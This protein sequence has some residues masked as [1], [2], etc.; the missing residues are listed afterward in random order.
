MQKISLQ[1]RSF[2][3]SIGLDTKN[4]PPELQIKTNSIQTK[5]PKEN[6]KFLNEKDW[7]IPH[8]KYFRLK[9]MFG[10]SNI[11][12]DGKTWIE[13]F[14]ENEKVEE[15]IKL[16]FKNPN[17]YYR[18]LKQLNQSSSAQG[19][20]IELYEDNG[21]FFVKEG[22]ARIALMMIKYLLEMSRAE[23]KEEKA[24]INKQ[25]VFSAIVRAT[26]KDRD[27]MYLINM[28]SEFYGSRVK[29]KKLD[30]DNECGYVM[31]LDDKKVEIKS[32][33]DFE[34]LIKNIYLPRE[35]KSYDKLKL[36]LRNVAKVGFEYK[37]N[38]ECDELV[39]Q[40]LLMGK[41][42][43]NYEIFIKYYKKIIQYKIEDDF[44]LKL[45]INN[46]TYDDVLKKL[47]KVVK[48]EEAM[49]KKTAETE[50]KKK[51]ISK[52][53]VSDS[54]KVASDKASE[55][56]SKEAETAAKKA[57]SSVKK[58]QKDVEAEVEQ[59]VTEKRIAEKTETKSKAKI[60]SRVDTKPE[61]D[62]DDASDDKIK[63]TKEVASTYI[64]NI[65]DNIEMTF[66]KLKSEE[67]RSMDLANSTGVELNIDKINDATINTNINSIKESS[68][69]LKK[70]IEAAKV[71]QDLNSSKETLEGLKALSGDKSIITEYGNEMK[72]IYMTSFNKNA[73]KMITDAKLKKLDKQRK[74]IEAEKCSFFSKLIGRAKLKQ[75]RLDNINLKE[76]LILTDSQYSS[77][78]YT[79][80]EDGLSD[81][82]AYVKTE[83]DAT[84][85]S[86]VKIYL[87]NI[88]SN[89]LL[90]EMIDRDKL[91]KKTRE[92]IDQQRNLPQIALSKEK[93]HLF[94]KAQIN[95]VQ[96]KNNELK[97]VIQINRA[98]SLKMQNTGV[99]PILG[100]INSTKAVRKF[101]TNLNQ[102]NITLKNENK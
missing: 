88:E 76:Q 7:T 13:I 55:A 75:A 81:I 71:L 25:Y 57:K 20:S 65:V 91:T 8:E 64:T 78:S 102:I 85:A 70:R 72:S 22:I 83:E 61:V 101:I 47:I 89:N 82:Y 90:K 15:I 31:K 73:R 60:N 12:L 17:Y 14:D 56:K 46:V 77:Y 34:V 37:E 92:K 100:N 45:D 9:N 3:N 67:A 44:I 84:C 50:E 53:K 52:T 18:D 86:D 10:T 51:K 97:R 95:M 26:P 27:V 94:S 16:Y 63:K 68:V 54:A 58:S 35:F 1:K 48:Q 74:E 21:K 49:V 2:F 98:N 99:I 38:D 30:N 4:L 80:L 6:L 28:L 62:S 66:F 5:I 79:S 69:G 24:I 39:D 29:L 59:L 40:F 93:K 87:K 23:S 11:Q 19:S 41:L 96:E 42:F 32:K 33:E 43:P 36:R